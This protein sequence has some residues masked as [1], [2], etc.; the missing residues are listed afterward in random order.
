MELYTIAEFDTYAREPVIA[1]MKDGSLICV[2]LTGGPTEPDNEN[3][4]AV[5]RSRDGGKSWTEPTPLFTHPKRGAWCTDIFTDGEY[6][7]AAVCLY[8][9]DSHYRELTTYFSESRDNGATWSAPKSIKGHLDGCSL[10]RGVTLSNGDVLYP[11]YWQEAVSDY[12]WPDNWREHLEIWRFCSGVGIKAKGEDVFYRY[13]YLADPEL[14]F[15]EPNAVEADPGHII[16]YL[17]NRSRVLYVTESFDYGRSWSEPRP[18][19]IPHSDSKTTVMKVG[20]D[21]IMINNAIGR[22]RTHLELTK[23]KNGLDFSH[24]CFIGEPEDNFYYPHAFADEEKRLLYV[25]YENSKLHRL[26]IF[27]FGELGIG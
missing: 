22:G 1:Q 17:R 25:A 5:S 15:W 9:A 20:G 19:G 21:I 10:R 18:T 23:S 16:M 27:T 24:V 4:A 2:F 11:L 8:N 7:V 14:S 3:F 26:A 13:G 6:P 12:N